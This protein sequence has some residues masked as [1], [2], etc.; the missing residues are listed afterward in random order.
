MNP[1]AQMTTVATT[2]IHRTPVLW[3]KIQIIHPRDDRGDDDMRPE[4]RRL[5]RLLHRSLAALDRD[6]P[7]AAIGR[8]DLLGAS[9][10]RAGRYRI[11]RDYSHSIVA[12][13]FDERSSAT[14]F[15]AGISFVMRLEIVSRG[16]RAGRPSRRSSRPRR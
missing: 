16:R 7:L 14:R 3:R 5:A 10:M 11:P 2:R 1:T 9:A 12:G 8:V 4:E 15:T 6:E 13:G